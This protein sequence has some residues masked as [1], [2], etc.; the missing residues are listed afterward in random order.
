MATLTVAILGP[1]EEGPLPL[2]NP[3]WTPVSE[4]RSSAPPRRGRCR[5]PRGA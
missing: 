3:D 1:S 2:L 4:L 5:P